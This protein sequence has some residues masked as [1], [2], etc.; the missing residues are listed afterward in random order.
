[1]LAGIIRLRGIVA[2][3]PQSFFFVFSCFLFFTKQ[4]AALYSFNHYSALSVTPRISEHADWRDPELTER[5]I[6]SQQ[7]PGR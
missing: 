2:L 5:D 3:L 1:M 6:D 4:A 7:Y